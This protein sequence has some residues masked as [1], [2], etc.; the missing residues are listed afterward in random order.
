[1]DLVVVFALFVFTLVPLCFSVA[2]VFSVNID[3]YTKSERAERNRFR[4]TPSTGKEQAAGRAYS[5][6]GGAWSGVSRRRRRR[7]AV[8]GARVT[9]CTLRRR[10]LF[11]DASLPSRRL[12]YRRQRP[13]P[14]CLLLLLLLAVHGRFVLYLCFSP[15]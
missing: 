6:D 9:G 11:N 10:W 12:N 5:C 14:R 3:L 4:E 1:M 7:C 15:G 2:T 13:P 8:L